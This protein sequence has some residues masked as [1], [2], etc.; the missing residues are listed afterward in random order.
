MLALIQHFS[1]PQTRASLS[2]QLCASAIPLSLLLRARRTASFHS[3]TS[4]R[5][6]TYQCSCICASAP[7]LIRSSVL[8]CLSLSP[9]PQSKEFAPLNIR[10]T[11]PIR[12]H[13]SAAMY[14]QF[15]PPKPPHVHVT[16]L[17]RLLDL[18][19]SGPL[20]QRAFDVPAHP[21]PRAHNHRY[22]TYLW[23]RSS[24]SLPLCGSVALFVRAFAHSVPSPTCQR[25]HLR[26]QKAFIMHRSA[27]TRICAICLCIR[28]FLKTCHCGLAPKTLSAKRTVAS[29]FPQLSTHVLVCIYIFGN[30]Q[31]HSMLLSAYALESIY[32]SLLQYNISISLSNI[33]PDL[34][35]P[36]RAS[37]VSLLHANL[38]RSSTALQLRKNAPFHFALPCQYFSRLDPCAVFPF[39]TPPSCHFVFFQN[40]QYLR[41][42]LY[43]TLLTHRHTST[44]RKAAVSS[45]SFFDLYHDAP[46][47]FY[48]F[49]SRRIRTF[50]RPRL[51][52]WAPGR[53]HPS[54]PMLPPVSKRLHFYVSAL[55]HQW[56]SA[57]L[58]CCTFMILCVYASEY[59]LLRTSD[60]RHICTIIPLHLCVSAASSFKVFAFCTTTLP[61]LCVYAPMRISEQ[62]I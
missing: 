16:V 14:I 31:L 21:H 5:E 40:L 24:I 29:I 37:T 10:A 48:V 28:T 49:Q 34:K 32:V 27:C 35:T 51:R 4:P 8:F 2:R 23:L 22:A 54:T 26:F 17:L 9:P 53:L 59:L 25:A 38:L 18:C 44:G 60:P 33:R 46:P 7:A 57:P 11:A 42:R 39:K 3:F 45:L 47:S 12:L 30:F 52:A 20:R 43:A 61:S 36:T 56:S 58:P 6:A 41:F 19:I 13:A 1:F 50:S 62:S 15:H 55:S